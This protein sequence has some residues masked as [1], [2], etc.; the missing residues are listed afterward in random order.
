MGVWEV[1]LNRDG[2]IEA[3]K[4]FIQTRKATQREP[5]IVVEIGTVGVERDGLVVAC[6]RL[7]QPIQTMQQRAARRVCVRKVGGKC[8]RPVIAGDCFPRTM[9]GLE[10]DRII[11]MS[12]RHVGA[13]RKGVDEEA[14][15]PL[16][17]T[18]LKGND[19]R[20]MQR[21]EGVGSGVE[22]LRVGS[23]R[24][25]QIAGALKLQ[26]RVELLTEMTFRNCHG[27]I[28]VSPQGDN[29]ARIGPARQGGKHRPLS[30][31]RLADLMKSQSSPT[32]LAVFLFNED[33]GP[34][35]VAAK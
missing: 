4:R 15:S 3:R 1:W 29:R 34:L 22:N 6:E 19:P 26:R 13:D 10:Y 12:D 16:E 21:L 18:G 2:A 24:G 32:G 7:L 25:I 35:I 30:R 28:T 23:L 31:S 27:S 11:D 5:A 8:Q 17:A 9:Q 20:H 33:D 14:R